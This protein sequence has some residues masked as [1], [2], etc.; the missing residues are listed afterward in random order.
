[1]TGSGMGCPDWPK[2]FGYYIPPTDISQVSWEPNK[3][4]EEGQMIVFEDALWKA[5]RSITTEDKWNHENWTR[6]DVHSYASFN[7]AH[8]W[9]EYINRLTGALTGIPVMILF[10]FSFVYGIRKKSWSLFLLSS[11]TLFFLGFE[12]WLGK[13]VVDGNLVPGQISLHMA[14]A[15]VLIILLL[16]ILNKTSSGKERIDLGRKGKLLVIAAL[17]LTC[18]QIFLGTQVREAV[19]LLIKGDII[20]RADWISELP[21][22]F[23]FHRSFSI[24]LIAINVW[25]IWL[26][27]RSKPSTRLYHWLGLILLLEVV[28]GVVLAYAGMPAGFQPTHLFFALLL[29]AVQYHL[30][31]RMKKKGVLN[32]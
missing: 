25:I 6:Y 14:G 8:T 11:A 18:L 26:G 31:L 2:C 27:I 15:A 3:V 12:A 5:N 28:A 17:L 9:T 16:I 1:M 22:I 19:D 32:E 7:P 23:L 10:F 4:F 29:L 13:I 24:A 20:E 21:D 30:L